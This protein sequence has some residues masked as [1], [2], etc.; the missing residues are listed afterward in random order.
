MKLLAKMI[1]C[2]V[3]AGFSLFLSAQGSTK[4]SIGF[5]LNPYIN[6]LLF[7]GT[8]FIP[9][10]ALRY[11]YN[12][13]DHFSFGPELSGHQIVMKNFEPNFISSSFNIGVYARYTF[14][15][16]S[17]IRPF[18]ELSPYYTFH[19]YKNFPDIQF[20]GTLPEMKS[21]YF[22]GYVAP[23]ITLFNKSRNV[24]LDLMY[25][26]SNKYFVNGNKSV[27]SYRLNINF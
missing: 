12:V 21:S 6:D 14:M 23:G 20:Y 3:F 2:L 18:L 8:S 16:E 19:S 10:Y 15:P 22:S 17:R 7:T 13:D 9:V 11:S 5:Q 4:H 27:F 1:F 25:K 26:F 24:S